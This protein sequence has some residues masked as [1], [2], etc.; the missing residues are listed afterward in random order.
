MISEVDA[1]EK[2]NREIPSSYSQKVVAVF[3]ERW[4][5]A[6]GYKYRDLTERQKSKRWSPTGGGLSWRF[7]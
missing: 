3:Y 7:D 5:P 4:T 6:R 2:S 1:Y